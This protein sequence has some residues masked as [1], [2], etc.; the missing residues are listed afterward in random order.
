ML[1]QENL[2]EYKLCSDRGNKSR[3]EFSGEIYRRSTNRIFVLSDVK[4]A[5]DEY[6]FASA[7]GRV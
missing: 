1:E 3:T 2:P 6:L 4:V 5:G 7:V